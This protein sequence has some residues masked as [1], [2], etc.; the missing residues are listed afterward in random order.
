[1]ADGNVA[2]WRIIEAVKPARG[3]AGLLVGA[4]AALAV[5]SAAAQGEF[6]FTRERGRA[7]VE[8]SNDDIHVVSAYYY[9]QQNHDSR[10]LL[11]QTAVSTTRLTTISREDFSL[12]TPDGREIPLASQTR[13]GEDVQ[14]IQLLLQ[15][16]ATVRHNVT[17]YFNQ[18][19]RTTSMRFFTLPF[20]GVVHDDFVVDAH[21]V[22]VSD[23]FFEAPTGRWEDGTY[24]L[25]VRHD[26]GRA[27]LPIEL[28]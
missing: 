20:G 9:S 8:F 13:V 21:Q 22:A 27:E 25:I 14:R 15:N 26:Q 28:E 5:T 19:D 23:L 12:R 2:R 17:S 18:R 4:L 10:W 6:P 7:A 1:L 16:A 11:I 3:L 24:A